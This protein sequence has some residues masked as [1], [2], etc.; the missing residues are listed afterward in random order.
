VK[1]E[2]AAMAE[3]DR[4][5]WTPEEDNRLR[6]LLEAGSPIPFVAADLKRSEPAVRRRAYGLRISLK[7]L[8]LKL[9]A[10]RRRAAHADNSTTA[11]RP[12]IRDAHDHHFAIANIGHQHLCAKTAMSDEQQ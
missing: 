10:M 6:T 5:V 1:G 12:A 4:N 8:K 9:K 2:I 3:N 7:R 11:I